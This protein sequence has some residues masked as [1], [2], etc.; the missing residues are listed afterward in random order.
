MSAV[1]VAL[2]QLY[3]TVTKAL[4]KLELPPD[5]AA[6]VCKVLMYAQKRNG[7]QGLIK[8]KERTILPDKN[9]NAIV[10]EHRSIAIAAVNGGGHTGMFVMNHAA[11]T[12][13]DLVSTCGIAMVNTSNTR[14][15]TGAI[16]YYA[17]QIA[18]HG[19]IALV[20]AG[21]PKV[22]AI[23]GGIDPVLGTN[24]ISIAIPT[25]NAP[26]IL[27][28][29]TAATTWFAVIN[30]RDNNHSLSEGVA[31]DPDGNPTIDPIK[32]MAGALRSIA[33]AK[34]SGLALMFEMLTAPLAGASIAGDEI[35]NRANTIIAIDPAVALGDNSFTQSIDLLINRIKNG[36][37]APGR[38][39]IRLPGEQSNK[40]AVECELQNAIRLDKNLYEHIKTLADQESAR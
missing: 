38:N 26:L 22:M 27:D 15:S 3:A 17:R 16:S 37:V 40:I 33:G 39:K 30:A 1:T 32:A 9:C 2:D 12:I 11:T 25:G 6:I 19:Y 28:M 10:T 31:V 21:S 8:I 14:S 23:E 4:I 20:L 7:T 36:R 35:D 18:E 34:G 13:I 24:P 29:A 5:E